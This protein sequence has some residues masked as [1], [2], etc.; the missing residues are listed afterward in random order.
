MQNGA[1]QY[2]QM[3]AH[4]RR[5]YPEMIIIPGTE[6][7]PFY[8][9]TG[10]LFTGD[11]TANDHER[12][13]LTVGLERPGDYKNL[14]V[15]HNSVRVT[16]LRTAIPAL[17]AF[18]AALLIG[19]YF[20]FQRRLWRIFGALLVLV[21]AGF[22]ANVLLTRP[23]PFDAYHGKQG[24]APY[25][26]FIDSVNRMGG[27][28][29]WNY[30]E[31]HSGVRS[32]GPITVKTLPYPEMLLE[33]K[34]YTGF[35]ALYGD[36]ITVTE[37]GNVW[38]VALKEYCRGFRERPPWGI[39]TADFHREGLAGQYLGDFQTVLLL[40]ERTL[41]AV[42]TALRN[43]KMYA[44]QGKF[45]RVPRLDEFSVSAAEPEAAP[46]AISGEEVLLAASPRIRISV[47]GPAGARETVQVRLIRSGS[48]IQT[49]KGSLPLQI[50]YRDPLDA[51]PGERVYYRMD[52]TGL[53]T[54][55]SNPIFVRFA[56][57]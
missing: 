43:G 42:L 10:N 22:I 15:L 41:A 39:A 45:P 11:L 3:I 38:D 50:D 40:S 30:P 31:T 55:V 35:A 23:T 47:S 16:E 13:I 57:Q 29:F 24:A 54:I 4:L 18:G 26:L 33:T 9:W 19:F 44:C 8:Y 5:A 46:R 14:P 2:L 48:L 21:G 37:P 6:S 32:L 51:T 36:A 17:A 52:M 27:L 49:F 53:G 56:K 12:R 25:Q 28:T 34:N 1:D 20:L 7:T